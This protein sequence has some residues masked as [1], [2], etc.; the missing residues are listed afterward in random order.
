MR[1]S[2]TPILVAAALLLVA[3]GC[4]DRGEA[5]APVGEAPSKGAPKIACDEPEFDFG[6]VAEGEEAKHTFKVRNAGDVPLKIE[7][8]RGG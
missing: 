4:R 2:P 1:R 8:A 6:A 5:P 7:S 3:A